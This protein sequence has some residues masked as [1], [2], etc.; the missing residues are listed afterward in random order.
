MTLTAAA[1]LFLYHYAL[2]AITKHAAITRPDDD[3]HVQA[4]M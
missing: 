1:R 3:L 4:M 2:G